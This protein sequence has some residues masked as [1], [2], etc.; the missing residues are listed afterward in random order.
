MSLLEGHGDVTMDRAGAADVPGA[1]RFARS[2]ASAASRREGLARLVQQLIGLEAKLRQ[3]AEGERFIEAV[4]RGRGAALLDRVWR[5]ARVAPDAG[6]DPAIPPRGSPGSGG[7][8]ALAGALTTGDRRSPRPVAAGCLAGAR[9]HRR[10]RPWPVRCRAAPTRSRSWS[11]P[12]AAGCEVDRRPRRPRAPPGSAGEAEVVAGPAPPASA[13][14]SSAVRVEVAPGPNLEAPGP[15]RPASCACPRAS[16]PATRRTT[17]PRRCWSTCSGVPALD[18]LAGHARRPDPPA[19]RP[20]AG[21]DRAPRA[22]TSASTPVHDPSNDDPRFRAQPGPPRAAPAVRRHR[23]PR[24][25]PGAGP[26]GRLL[27]DDA[28]LLDASPPALLD[29]TDAG[30]AGR[31]PRRPGPPGGAGV[32]GRSAGPYPPAADAV[33]RVLA[34][35]R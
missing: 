13:P 29:P 19:A 27:A 14:P 6:G 23:R 22:T 25:R 18:G 28:D 31:R 16:P 10:A 3:Y 15:R 9:S 12:C 30:G 2:C 24:R 21:R 17:R 8:S 5:G 32:A 7:V 35:A 33:D 26:P 34:V 20:A 4:E 11:W 1:A